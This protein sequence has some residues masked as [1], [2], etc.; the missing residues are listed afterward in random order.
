MPIQWALYALNNQGDTWN[1]AYL[2]MFGNKFFDKKGNIVLDDDKGVKA[3]KWLKKTYDAGLT[4]PGAES[5]SSNDV[6]YVPKP[7]TCDRFHKLRFI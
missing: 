3:A 4:N 6:R 2:R 1:L 5:V 7:K